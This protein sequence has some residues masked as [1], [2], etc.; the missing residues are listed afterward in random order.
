VFLFAFLAVAWGIPYLMIAVVVREWDP[1]ML[2]LVR[3]GGAAVVLLPIAIARREVPSVL[4]HWKPVLAYAALEVGI[5]W[6][7]LG[8]AE[9]HLPSSTT[10]LLLAAVPLAGIG[11]GFLLRTRSTMSPINL[12]GLLVGVVG[13]ALLIGFDVR[14]SDLGSVGE[15]A[16]V[17][18]GYALGPAILA[19]WLSDVSGV[20]VSAF[21]LGA[22][23]VAYVPV[24]VLRHAWPTAIPSAGVVWSLVTLILVC[25]AGAFVALAGLVREVGAVRATTVTYVNP[26]I[27]LL[28]GALVL[29]EPVGLVSIVGFAVILAGCVLTAL[30][31]RARPGDGVRGADA[32]APTPSTRGDSTAAA[33]GAPSTRASRRSSRR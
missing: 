15:V 27:A 2:V 17:V 9:E 6:F 31:R 7:F 13:V 14:G 23:A 25:S 1:S 5:P 21:A 19:R 11:V 30:P 3:T 26:A 20:A 32:A 12:V 24:V 22:V 4:R 29:H 10:G 33:S 16:I 28:A 8:S 18:V